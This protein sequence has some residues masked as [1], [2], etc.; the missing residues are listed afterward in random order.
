MLALRGRVAGFGLIEVLVALT[1]V[2]INAV[3]W[4]ATL[5][6]VF[7]LVRR[8]GELSSVVDP[9]AVASVACGL[10]CLVPRAAASGVGRAAT[11]VSR[12]RRLRR[13]LGVSLIELLIA[14]AVGAMVLGGLATSIAVTGRA[15]RG[16]TQAADA[17]TVRAALPALL[18]EVVEATGRGMPD[19]CGLDASAG[20]SRLVVRRALGDGSVVVD[21]VFAG[22]DGGGRPALYLR[23]V[24]HARQPWVEDVTAF[25]VERVDLAPGTALDEARVERVVVGVSHH[26]LDAPLVVEIGLPHRPCLVALP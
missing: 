15:A 14:L 18:R 9:A 19:A 25:V 23:R 26:S 5:Q 17:A 12:R 22:L 2:A 6:V 13:E 4:T 3:G 1:I 11:C 8:I 24:P 7:V 16:A 20:A 21:E 10:G